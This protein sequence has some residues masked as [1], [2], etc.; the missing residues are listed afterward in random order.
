FQSESGLDPAAVLPH[1]TVGQFHLVQEGLVRSMKAQKSL[2]MAEQV[3]FDRIEQLARETKGH[4]Q[5][6]LKLFDLK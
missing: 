1:Q 4:D 6:Q 5:R 2:I 3:P